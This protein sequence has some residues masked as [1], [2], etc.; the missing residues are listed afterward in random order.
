MR[1]LWGW[2]LIV[3]FWLT[4]CA[5][6][7]PSPRSMPAPSSDDGTRPQGRL[8]LIV[9]YDDEKS[10][11][12]RGDLALLVKEKDRVTALSP[13]WYRVAPDGS[14]EDRSHPVTWEVARQAQIPLMPLVTNKEGKDSVLL[15]PDRQE[16]AV[17]SLMAKVDEGGG[18]MQGLIL[19]FE[20]LDPASREALTAFAERLARALHSRGKKLGVAVIPAS[21]D[22][23][24]SSPYDYP[25]LAQVAD[26]L[27]L[28]TYDQH[29]RT[30]APGP[31]ASLSWVEGRLNYALQKGVPPEKIDLGVATYGYRWSG[32]KGEDLPMKAAK[33]LQPA[34]SRDADESPHFTY[35]DKGREWAVWYEDEQ[36]ARHKVALAREK[37]LLGVAVWRL[38][39]EDEAF[40]A[41][42]R[43]EIP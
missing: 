2:V 12:V 19:D 42:L 37:G 11:D 32:G 18:L 16:A 34:P 21:V 17:E 9:F 27:I 38:G 28:M 36:S 3:G 15:H 25:A 31:V 43:R 22:T 41:M 26:R 13:N 30:S 35:R 8:Q 7:G 10:P 5:F 24:G 29:G 4:G 40:W 23:E 6:W 20:L 39:Y 33:A 14:V 1:R